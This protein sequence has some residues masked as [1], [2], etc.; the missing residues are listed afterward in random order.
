MAWLDSY[1]KELTDLKDLFSKEN[2]VVVHHRD[3]DGS[4]SVSQFLKFFHCKTFSIKDPFIPDD[5]I[6]EL[7]ELKPEVVIFMDIGVDEHWQRLVK[8]KDNIPGTKIVLIDHHVIQ[9]DIN[10]LEMMH[11]NPRFQDPDAY[12]PASLMVFDILTALGLKTKSMSWIACI[13]VISDYGHKQNK[14]FI[15]V[16]KKQYSTLLDATDLIDSKLGTAAKTIY[17]AIVL[18]GEYGVRKVVDILVN[19]GGFEEFEETRDLRKWKEVVDKEVENI[20]QDFEKNKELRGNVIFFEIKSKLNLASIISNIISQK[21]SDKIIVIGKNVNG[22]WKVSARSPKHGSGSGKS[23]NL[24]E[25]VKKACEGIGYGGGHPQA[26]GA[27]V[28]DWE[29]FKDRV[30][31]LISTSSK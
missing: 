12:V 17:S 20:I 14:E 24:A 30:V 15:D 26:A 10:K 19:S 11:I 6:A 25:V 3:V 2:K 13:G 21:F 7:A 29:K 31:S 16:C 8:I 23:V 4:C 9:K 1:K 22:S 27:S 18:K 5:L 28:E